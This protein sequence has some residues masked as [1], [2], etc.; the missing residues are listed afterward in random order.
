MIDY[1]GLGLEPPPDTMRPSESGRVSGKVNYQQWLQD[2][3]MKTQVEVLGKTRAKLFAEGR[4]M[5][6]DL[7][8]SDRTEYNLQQLRDR[9]MPK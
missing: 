2:Q 7:L 9:L 1:E 4:V 6:Q 3:P 5:L 8:W